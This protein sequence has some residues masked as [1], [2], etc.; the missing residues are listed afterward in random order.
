MAPYWP[1]KRSLARKNDL[2]GGDPEPLEQLEFPI[3]LNPEDDGLAAADEA[4]VVVVEADNGDEV[5]FLEAVEVAEAASEVVPTDNDV[6]KWCLL[7]DR[8]AIEETS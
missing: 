3:E 4:V 7:P 8:T 1:W 5:L 2:P 6:L